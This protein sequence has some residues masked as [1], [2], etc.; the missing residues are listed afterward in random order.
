[1]L[2]CHICQAILKVVEKQENSAKG[3]YCNGEYISVG[4][5]GGDA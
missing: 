2:N 3:K 5:S 1:M 4:G